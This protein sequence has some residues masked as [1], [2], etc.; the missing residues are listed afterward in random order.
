MIYIKLLNDHSDYSTFANSQNFITPNITFCD[1]EQHTHYNPEIE[2]SPAFLDILYSDVNGNLSYTSEVLS[3][4]ENKTP[5]AL[6]IVPPGF[7]GT[8]EPGRWMSLKFMNYSTPEAGS[9]NVQGMVWGNDNNDI[10]TIDNIQITYN[11]SNTN[12]GFL[13]SDWI[14]GTDN[15]I[16]SL[17]TVNNE[18][19]TSVLGTANQYAV[20]D[21]DGKNK[22]DKI[23]AT[24]TAQT[25]W[26]TDTT[27][28]NN[29]GINYAPVA[30]CC[31][32]YHTLG[33]QAGDWY[34]PACGELSILVVK[35]PDINNKLAAINA[36]YPNNCMSSMNTQYFWTSTEYNN[37]GAYTILMN[38]GKISITLKRS[39]SSIIS[40]LQY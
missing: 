3:T 33:T 1:N 31:A 10:S 4:S 28:T 19:N 29:S 15:K 9:I 37:G 8:N 30:C 26:E 27:I 34:L 22:T 2:Q 38:T 40:M 13:T 11:G 7:F 25:T 18:W 6:C 5:I 39:A 24:A 16:P 21:I 20:T 23:L 35:K 17:F 36:V 32:R 12:W 14:V